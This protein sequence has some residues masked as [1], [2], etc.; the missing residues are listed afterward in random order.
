MW[1][2]RTFVVRGFFHIYR[3]EVLL[4]QSI[5]C[6]LLS[7]LS[8]RQGTRIPHKVQCKSISDYS[9]TVNSI[10]NRFEKR[11]GEEEHFSH[12]LFKMNRA[13]DKN[14]LISNH[15]SILLYNFYDTERGAQI[16]VTQKNLHNFYGS[17]CSSRNHFLMADTFQYWMH[18][19]KKA[20]LAFLTRR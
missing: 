6:D 13:E 19:V 8:L 11:K 4:M 20:H 10:W 3:L 15:S 9:I 18:K 17:D 5:L 1:T 2:P 14:F 12:I 16:V 7:L